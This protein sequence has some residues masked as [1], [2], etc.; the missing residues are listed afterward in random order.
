MKKYMIKALF[1][2][3]FVIAFNQSC[4]DLDE[5]VYS[6]V[7]TDDFFKNNDEFIAALGA[8]YTNLYGFLNHGNYLST[9]EVSSDEIMIPQ[10]GGDW[11]DGGQWLRAHRHEYNANDDCVTNSWNFLF[12][13]VNTCNRLIFTFEKLIG[14]G[15]VDAALARPFIA[16]LKVLRALWYFWLLDAFG[17]VPIVDRFDVPADFKPATK[18]RAEVYAFVDKELTDNV[19]LLTKDKNLATYARV[20]YWVGKSIQAKLY[21]NAGVYTG[22]PQWDKAI[23]AADEI[24]NSNNYAL[25]GNYFANFNAN[26]AASKENIFVIPYDQVFA[27]GFNMPQMTLHYGSQ[28]TF[29]LTDQP[30]NGYCTLQE[31][32]ESYETTDGRKGISGNQQIRGNFHAGPQYDDDGRTVIID[33]SADDP[34]GKNLVFTPQINAH[35]PNCFRQAGA[36]VGKFEFP[37]GAT[38]NLNTDFP[39]FRYADILLTKAEG[40]WRKSAGDAA[41]LALVNQIRARAG[42][43]APFTSLTSDNFLAERG[44]E[45]FYEGWRRQDQIRFGAWAKTWAFKPASEKCKEIWPIPR[46][47]INANA[48]LKQNPCY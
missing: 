40:L 42:G 7:K 6:S 18:T 14:E 28:A 35:F 9:Q 36:R 1:V 30:W 43:V 32:Y 31:F 4:S 37:L 48:N 17:N 29:N 26:N 34:D 22:T 10:R 39:I 19:P 12:G 5:N 33:N 20:N 15:K 24:I 2:G 21:L 47:Q 3:L 44:R 16:E 23:A 38:P 46:A 45:M 41:A 13:G 25:E 8:A 27:G 11:F